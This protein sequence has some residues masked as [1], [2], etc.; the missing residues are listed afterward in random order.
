MAD[1]MSVISYQSS[2]TIPS[3]S[4]TSDT[5]DFLGSSLVG[6]IMPAAFTGTSITFQMSDSDTTYCDLYNK[7]GTQLQA[8]VA[9]SRAIFFAPGDFIGARWVKF[10]SNATEGGNRTIKVILREMA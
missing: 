1:F 9:P 8:T 4:N 2:V 6:I 3:G 10:V 5:V 7:D